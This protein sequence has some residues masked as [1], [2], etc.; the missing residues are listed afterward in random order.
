MIGGTLNAISANDFFL[1]H[2]VCFFSCDQRDILKEEVKTISNGTKLAS[3]LNKLFFHLHIYSLWYEPLDITRV[4]AE[5]HFIFI[6]CEVHT[7]AEGVKII[8]AAFLWPPDLTP[9]LGA[10]LVFYQMVIVRRRKWTVFAAA[11]TL[12][13]CWE[14]G[15]IVP[16]YSILSYTLNMGLGNVSAATPMVGWWALRVNISTFKM[17]WRDPTCG[18]TLWFGATYPR[19][20]YFPYECF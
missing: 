19:F 20:V 5:E 12:C 8:S 3:Q 6:L 11:G 17:F 15:F 9:S 1:L 4:L 14:Y 18:H 13:A 7:K 16:C 2:A 10:G